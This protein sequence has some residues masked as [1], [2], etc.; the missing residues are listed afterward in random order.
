MFLKIINSLES[1][2]LK[3][4]LHFLKNNQIS[5]KLI[6]NSEFLIYHLD[7]N[8]NNTLSTHLLNHEG[9]LQLTAIGN[10]PF[11]AS[12]SFKEKSTIIT[13]KNG[14]KIGGDS[15]VTIAGPCAVESE[16]SL[17]II[18]SFIHQNQ[19]K[20]LRGGCYKPRTSPYSFQ[21]LEEEGLKLLRKY[22]D[23]YNLTVVSEIP[24]ENLLPTFEKYVD[25]IQVGARNMQ[26]F[27]LLKALGQSK[28]PIL[29]KRGLS[30][31]IEEWLQAAE[32]VLANGNEQVIL[33]ERGIRTFE[34][35]TRNTLD[36]SAVLAVK[37]LSHLP[38]I[39]DPSHASGRWSMIEKLSLA[40][41]A[42]GAD[43]IIIEIHNNPKNA[44]SDGPQS[45]ELEKYSQLV[46]KL[47]LFSSILKNNN[48]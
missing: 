7:K 28:T 42:V 1:H 11:L 19:G 30:N 47:E 24:N 23:K 48:L 38:I 34:T 10:T 12:K 32:Y 4:I 8:I 6:S 40:S 45:L 37:E 26:N 39:V 29:L 36:I 2:K 33:C 35:Y 18:A 27:S 14:T 16:E 15:F 31:T 22:G 9:V 46:T 44:L 13:L 41:L 20:I 25:I 17:A 3:N 21:G 5:F 43:G